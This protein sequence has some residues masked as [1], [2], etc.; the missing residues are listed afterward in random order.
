VRVDVLFP[1][2][3]RRCEMLHEK[4]G[5]YAS[6][7]EAWGVMREEMYELQAE[8]MLRKRDWGR[9]AAEA[10]DLAVVA[11]RLAEWA[12]RGGNER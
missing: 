10:L 12:G 11:I 6:G 7:H 2:I 3:R 1:E 5:D 8:L 9:V 4:Y